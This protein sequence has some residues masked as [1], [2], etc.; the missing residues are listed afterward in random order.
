MEEAA[1]G[2][3]GAQEL[4]PQGG[5][6]VEGRAV[7]ALGGEQ[8]VDAQ[9][10]LVGGVGTFGAVAAVQGWAVAAVG[11][12]GAAVGVALDEERGRAVGVGGW[13]EGGED[14]RGMWSVEREGRQNEV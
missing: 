5:R 11:G 2:S 12:Q 9:G 13:R 7:E 3:F 1:G 8:L 10:S 14:G 6:V 4:P